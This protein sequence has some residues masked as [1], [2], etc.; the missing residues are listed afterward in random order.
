MSRFA[1][2]LIGGSLLFIGIVAFASF[3]IPAITPVAFPIAIL[4][5]LAAGFTAGIVDDLRK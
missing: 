4:A 3:F 5:F 1:I 2:T